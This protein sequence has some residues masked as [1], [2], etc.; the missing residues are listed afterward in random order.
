M[1]NFSIAGHLDTL[2]VNGQGYDDSDDP[3]VTRFS[4]SGSVIPALHGVVP[5][6]YIWWTT[7]HHNEDAS[8][9]GW[10]LCVMESTTTTT[11]TTITIA[12]DYSSDLWHVAEGACVV[13]AEGCITSPNHPASYFE[14]DFC[15][16]TVN[17]S[18]WTGRLIVTGEGIDSRGSSR[19]GWSYN[20]KLWVDGVDGGCPVGDSYF[21]WDFCQA[22]AAQDRVPQQSIIWTTG[23]YS[24]TYWDRFGWKICEGPPLNDSLPWYNQTWTCDTS[25]AQLLFPRAWRPPNGMLVYQPY[26]KQHAC[27]TVWSDPFD[28]DGDGDLNNGW[29]YY[30]ASNIFMFY[31]GESSVDVYERCG[32]CPCVAGEEQRWQIYQFPSDTPIFSASVSYLSCTPCAAGRFREA[33]GVVGQESACSPCAAGSTSVAG[34]T[35]C[36][37]CVGGQHTTEEGLS[38]CSLCLPGTYG[39]DAG[40][41]ACRVGHFTAVEGATACASCPSGYLGSSEGLSGC[42]PCEAGWFGTYFACEE[43]PSGEYAASLGQSRCARCSVGTI[44]PQMRSS[45]CDACPAGQYGTNATATACETCDTGTYT[46]LAASSACTK[47][48]DL[49]G[50]GFHLWT[51]VGQRVRGGQLRWVEVD[52]SVAVASCMCVEGARLSDDGACTVCGEGLICP[53]AGDVQLQPGYFAAPQDIASV[54]RCHG[55]DPGRCPGGAPGVCARNRDNSSIACGECDPNMRWTSEG[56]CEICEP[57]DVSF[58]L[59][60]LFL[61]TLSLL[62]VYSAVVTESRAKNN[63]HVV[64]LGTLGSQLVTVIQMMGVC[65]LLSVTWPQPFSTILSFA[66]V[67]NF[68][69]EILNV[70]CVV[71]MSVVTRYAASAFGCVMLLVVMC[72][73]HAS[74]MFLFHTR[75]MLAGQWKLF[76]PAL[77]GGLGSIF[78]M[79]YIS[80][81]ATISAPLRCQAHPNGRSTVAAYP[82]VVCWSSLEH[83][84][85]LSVGA[86]ASCIPIGFLT[87]VSIVLRLLPRFLARGDTSFLHAFSF[88]FFRFKPGAFWY[89]SVLL[90]RSTGMALAPVVHDETLQLFVSVLILL[91]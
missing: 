30:Y 52:G 80:V 74:H 21:D 22:Q 11:T 14:Y 27:T 79:C 57:S 37:S 47:C 26:P 82:Q 56:P 8:S 59:I 60:V 16:I 20:D 19:Y 39:I 77:V 89:V 36:S 72:T 54:W 46:N 58:L 78:M 81:V 53:L 85:M 71:G 12:T 70:S 5:R 2:T 17:R 1:V 4:Q 15:N 86:A 35:A 43:C 51:T 33:G 31:Y 23:Y 29:P 69:L 7:E 73:F 83:L 9:T 90:A 62:S 25:G 3:F 68:K 40:C 48:G 28:L 18:A 84:H 64:L 44:S 91:P 10:K 50:S 63:E 13:D 38:A 67:L 49:G 42:S 32:P 34:A 24:S 6:G 65:K 75:E 45:A 87:T 66:S 41:E 61:A 76:R 88:L 55:E